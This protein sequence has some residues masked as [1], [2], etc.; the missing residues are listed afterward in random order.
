[1][2]RRIGLV[3]GLFFIG[4]GGL[5]GHL[6]LVCLLREFHVAERS[7]SLLLAFWLSPLLLRYFG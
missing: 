3:D 4:A 7:V 6:L 5:L 1:M 2:T